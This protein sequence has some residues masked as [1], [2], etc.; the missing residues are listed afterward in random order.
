[1]AGRPK[2][3]SINVSPRRMACTFGTDGAGAIAFTQ[4][5]GFSAVAIAGMGDVL[6]SFRAAAE[7]IT[8]V[9]TV[10]VVAVPGSGLVIPLASNVACQ[11]LV[12]DVGGNLVNLA[13]TVVTVQ[14]IVEVI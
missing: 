12:R 7:N 4:N 8:G 9:C 2:P 5:S 6:L 3:Q 10:A 13:A 11:V 14:V 1:M